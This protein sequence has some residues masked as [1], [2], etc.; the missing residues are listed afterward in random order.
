MTVRDRKAGSLTIL[1]FKLIDLMDYRTGRK[2]RELLICPSS[3]GETG[4]Y[5]CPRCD[6]VLD[7]EFMHFCDQCG[8][9]LDWSGYRH[10][11]IRA[12]H[13]LMP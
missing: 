7:R 4:F 13:R 10:A 5:I 8:Q 6:C 3:F 9:K 1:F 11:K 12:H 2:V